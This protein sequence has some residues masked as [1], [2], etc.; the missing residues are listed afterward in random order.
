MTGG[1]VVVLGPTGKN[2]AA[3]MSGGVAYVLDENREL[4]RKLN[5]SMVSLDEITSKYDVIELKEMIQEHVA[6]TNSEKGKKIL[7]NFGEYLPLFKKV[8]PYDYERMLKTFA[9]MEAKGLSSE[10][11]QIEAFYANTRQ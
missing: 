10:Q 8:M 6:Y 2:F 11:A 1:R 7:E 3:G 4:Y 5:K 9:E